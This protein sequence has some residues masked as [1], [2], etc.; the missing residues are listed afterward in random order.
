MLD[1]KTPILWISA[2]LIFSASIAAQPCLQAAKEV[3]PTMSDVTRTT[4]ERKLAEA[5]AVHVEVPNA[6]DSIIW[7][8]RRTAYLGN[9][10]NAVRIFSSGIVLPPKEARLY[11]HRGHRY[12]TVRCFDDAIRDLETAAKLINGKPDEIEPD[13]LPNAKNTPTSTLQSNVWYHLGLA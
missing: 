8:G 2:V 11:R 3:A 6:A 13:G 1:M 7:L 9:Y 5:E 12:L 10:T 4:Y